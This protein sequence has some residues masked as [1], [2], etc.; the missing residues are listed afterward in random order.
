MFLHP[1]CPLGAP[2]RFA[3]LL[4]CI[5]AHNTNVLEFPVTHV[6][7]LPSATQ[8][9]S[10]CIEQSNESPRDRNSLP[11]AH[12]NRERRGRKKALIS[13]A[14]CRGVSSA[15]KWPPDGMRVH[16]VMLP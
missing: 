14:S 12:A 11:R 1:L 10:P 3:G 9:D 5:M 16:R 13:S 4:L 8:T 15:G 7:E 2:E 6:C